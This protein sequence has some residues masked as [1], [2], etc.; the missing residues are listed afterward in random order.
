M[1]TCKFYIL[2]FRCLHLRHVA[3]L[4]S[5][6]SRPEVATRAERSSRSPKPIVLDDEIIDPET[7]AASR[8]PTH[9]NFTIENNPYDYRIDPTKVLITVLPA[10][11]VNALYTR[12][13]YT[14]E[15]PL[16]EDMPGD[17]LVQSEY[18]D[19][20]VSALCAKVKW[21]GE[22]M[23]LARCGGGL[24]WADDQR[25]RGQVETLVGGGEGS[26]KGKGKER[27]A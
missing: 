4:S 11:A 17:E 14:P 20:P 26:G 9:R 5:I 22:T 19:W 15:E 16:A 10:D 21:S 12:F 2:P 8:H 13:D 1:L 24:L 27:A 23:G 6:S 25:V 7:G 18:A 3:N